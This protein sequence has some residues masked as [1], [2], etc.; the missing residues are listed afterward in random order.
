MNEEEKQSEYEFLYDYHSSACN[1]ISKC[2]SVVAQLLDA[3][4]A[5]E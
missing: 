4:F 1:A 2:V 3:K 5:D